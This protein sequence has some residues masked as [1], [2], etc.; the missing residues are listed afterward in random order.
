MLDD[1][2]GEDK[3]VDDGIWMLILFFVLGILFCY[4]YIIGLFKNENKWFGIEEFLFIECGLD[5][6]KDLLKSK[7]MVYDI[8]VDCLQFSGI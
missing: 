5:V 1:G 8:F 6:S 2:K 4:K 3:V 7:M